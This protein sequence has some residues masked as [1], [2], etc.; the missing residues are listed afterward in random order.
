MGKSFKRVVGALSGA[1]LIGLF[2]GAAHAGAVSEAGDAGQRLWSAQRTAGGEAIDT[3]SGAL[4][5]ASGTDY[6]DLFRIY[7]YAGT[8]FSATTSASSIFTNNFDT[9]LFLF[10]AKGY[11]VV[12]NDDDPLAG[13]TSTIGGLVDTSGYY[14]LAIAGA[15]YTPVSASGAIFGSLIGQD[16][17]GAIGPGG[18]NALS[19]WQ[20]ITSEEGAYE[21]RLQGAF[22]GPAPVPE[23]QTMLLMLSGLGL[24]GAAAR[25]RKQA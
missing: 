16:Q 20:S 15:G 21:I 5:G 7:L 13:P 11:G 18:N 25:R 17:V 22:A 6:V 9:S 4:L 2:S 19:G 12:A 23:P 10:D 3:I 1:V 8:S 24:L 14:Y